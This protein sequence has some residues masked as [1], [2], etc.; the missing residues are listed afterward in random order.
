MPGKSTQTADK[1]DEWMDRLGVARRRL[2]EA[3]QTA[4]DAEEEFRDMV[5]GAFDDGLSVT[6]IAYATNLT[7]SRVYQIKAGRRT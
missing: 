7:P 6:P 4:S 3:R 5:R 2:D 1:V